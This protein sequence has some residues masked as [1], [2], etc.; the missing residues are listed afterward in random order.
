MYD[1]SH[2]SIH[3]FDDVIVVKNQN[4][5]EKHFPRC[6]MT[7]IEMFVLNMIKKGKLDELL[8]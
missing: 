1:N 3:V 6:N 8:Q 7:K 4:G 2:L 5:M